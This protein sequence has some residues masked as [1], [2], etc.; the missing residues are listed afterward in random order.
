MSSG[1]MT[2]GGQFTTIWMKTTNLWCSWHL[3]YLHTWRSVC[4]NQG[5][6]YIEQNK[7]HVLQ[8]LVVQDWA[9]VEVIIETSS[10]VCG[11]SFLMIHA[12]RHVTAPVQYSSTVFDENSIQTFCTPFYPYVEKCFTL[13]WNTSH[14]FGKLVQVVVG[15]HPCLLLLTSMSVVLAGTLE[16]MRGAPRSRVFFRG[17]RWWQVSRLQ[18]HRWVPPP[19]L[20]YN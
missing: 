11:E 7:L 13:G 2:D 17:K 12:Q 20:L 10:R 3:Q 9:G 4:H 14:L 8:P 16:T 18:A 6:R 19:L 1:R 15:F 5:L